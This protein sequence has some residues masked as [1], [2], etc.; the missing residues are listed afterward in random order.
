MRTTSKWHT[1][2]KWS[3]LIYTVPFATRQD[4]MHFTKFIGVNITRFSL[5]GCHR[6]GQGWEVVYRRRSLSPWERAAN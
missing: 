4:A 2:N 1:T 3:E 5:V 6:A